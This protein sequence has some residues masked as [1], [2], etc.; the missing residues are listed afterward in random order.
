MHI[1]LIISLIFLAPVPLF[2][3]Q[4][5]LP[6]H[7]QPVA[8]GVVPIDIFSLR[9]YSDPRGY[10]KSPEGAW[11]KF[12]DSI[13]MRSG[14]AFL[15]EY[16]DRK[17]L[18]TNVHVIDGAKSGSV[19]AIINREKYRLRELGGDTFYD[20]A[21]M[22]FDE[23]P[24][25]S[26][27]SPLTFRQTHPYITM[28][29]WVVARLDGHNPWIEVGHINSLSKNRQGIAGSSDYI[30]MSA[31]LEEGCSGGPLVDEK[32]KVVGVNSWRLDGRNFALS[33][34]LSE[35]LIQ[36]MINNQGRVRRA[37]LGIEWMQIMES[38]STLNIRSSNSRYPQIVGLIPGGPAE[39]CMDKHIHSLVR[40]IN[41][42]PVGTLQ[43]ILHIMEFVSPGEK[44]E[45][46]LE[47]EEDFGRD[48]VS[49]V[50]EELDPLALEQIA[51]YAMEK[52][53]QVEL[54]QEGNFLV[55]TGSF[56]HYPPVSGN[57]EPIA[58]ELKIVATGMEAS[59]SG[60]HK[61][62][63]KTQ[64]DLGVLIRLCSMKSQFFL[65]GLEGDQFE[66]VPIS[67]SFPYSKKTS[68]FF[69]A[70]YY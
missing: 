48:T 57:V 27:L 32:G 50:A 70:L 21:V 1:L 17:Y 20:L 33:G 68:E 6:Q 60:L 3:Q 59:F 37:Y 40:E 23:R 47:Q 58:R 41:G 30:E 42:Q 64:K 2:A 54:T 29:V 15:Y 67:L 45:V 38:G 53:A 36:S 19:H 49:L 44:V 9:R 69:S 55:A 51:A 12:R 18:I 5:L 63:V 22:E 28:P 35:R 65:L 8:K 7:L 14:T 4:S 11:E 66:S 34:A 16:K 39:S 43:D 25:L 62:K 26:G 31:R 56:A 61:Y 10:L 24:A 13:P 46:I 52:R